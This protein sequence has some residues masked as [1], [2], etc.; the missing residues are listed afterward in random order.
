[1]V[2]GAVACHD[3]GDT[4]MCGVDDNKDNNE[5]GAHQLGWQ[6]CRGV[7]DSKVVGALG[8]LWALPL[9]RVKAVVVGNGPTCESV[10]C[11]R[12]C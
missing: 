12:E 8:A 6:T 10:V 7:G 2:H 9:T 5:T 11:C 4:V 1:M 3:D